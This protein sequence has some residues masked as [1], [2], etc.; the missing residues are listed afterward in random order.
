[1]QLFGFGASTTPCVQDA[2][3][4]S[5]HL[6]PS[7]QRVSLLQRSGGTTTETGTLEQEETNAVV[8][9]RSFEE[10][11]KSDCKNKD[12]NCPEKAQWGYCHS[13]E[14]EDYMSKKCKHSCGIC[15]RE[16]IDALKQDPSKNK[17][18]TP[19]E[20]QIP[21]V[22]PG[23]ERPKLIM[24]VDVDY[25]P[26]ALLKQPPFDKRTDLDNVVGVGA[27]MITAMG[28]HCGFD[29]A[30]MQ[31][32][33][34]DCWG[35]NEIGPGLREGWYHGCMTYTHATGVR[36]RYV[37]F[38]N[39]WAKP[40][41]PSG[42]IVKLVDGRP[43]FNGFDSLHGRT[44]VDVTGWAPTADT[45]YFVKNQCTG[46]AYKGFKI[47]QGSDIEPNKPKDAK[48]PNDR[49]LLAVLEGKAD[50]MW[51][52]GDQAANYQ[53]PPGTVE[54]GWNCDLW[55][56]F[57]KTFAYVQSGMFG[58]M[59]NGTTIAMSKKGSGVAGFLDDCFEKFRQT[60]EFYKVCATK[61]HG[62][63]QVQTCIPNEYFKSDPEFKKVDIHHSPYMFPTDQQ[64]GC[65]SGYC[66]C[67][68]SD[69]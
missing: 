6:T 41:K 12:S 56:G 67:S 11:L 17:N 59:H 46:K 54:D 31:V 30:I 40:N 34:A 51:I 39:S 19:L 16:E 43:L 37:E 36:N 52:Y 50:A 14:W 66:S 3:P 29:V 2:C 61:Y 25:P 15:A 5:K 49:A 28:K 58:W 23:M 18:W 48:G 60:E 10:F 26:Y 38:T 21:A 55:S 45:L 24:G 53:C 20:G 9:Y 4:A 42:L 47:I 57:G 65:G 7:T 13:I 64:Q 69:K 32:K 33:W 8:K 22:M 1:M 63:S 35:K 62:H 27:D 68:S 44:I